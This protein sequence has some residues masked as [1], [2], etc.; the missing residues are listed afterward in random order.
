M[1]ARSLIVV[2]LV[3]SACSKST[4]PSSQPDAAGVGSDAAGAPDTATVKADTADW[5]AN[6]DGPVDMAN[7]ARR[8][9]VTEADL[10]APADEI[11]RASCRERA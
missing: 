4:S 7:D 11:G 5:A 1:R 10:S 6:A 3:V 2:L 8:D 9:A